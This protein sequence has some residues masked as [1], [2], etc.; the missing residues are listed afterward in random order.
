MKSFSDN[1]ASGDSNNARTDDE[2]KNDA[3][4]TYQR[5]FWT[6]NLPAAGHTGVYEYLSS[7]RPTKDNND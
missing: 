3:T 1:R 5:Y 6:E 4:N 7:I 2:T